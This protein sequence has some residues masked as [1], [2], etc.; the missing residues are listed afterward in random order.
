MNGNTSLNEQLLTDDNYHEIEDSPKEESKNFCSFL[1][2]FKCPIISTLMS[3]IL[4]VVPIAIFKKDIYTKHIDAPK[5][6][7]IDNRINFAFWTIHCIGLIVLPILMKCL[8]KDKL[9]QFCYFIPPVMMFANDLSYCMPMKCYWIPSLIEYLIAIVSILILP[10][11]SIYVWKLE[12]FWLGEFTLMFLTFV[13]ISASLDA[14]TLSYILFGR[15]IRLSK[16]LIPYPSNPKNAISFAEYLIDEYEDYIITGIYLS[17]YSLFTIFSVGH[18]FLMSFKNSVLMIIPFLL[19][20]TA[21]IISNKIIGIILFCQIIIHILYIILLQF[22]LTR[23]FLAEFGETC[24][25]DPVFRKTGKKTM[26]T[27][28]IG[29]VITLLIFTF[30]IFALVLDGNRTKFP[31]G[32]FIGGLVILSVGAFLHIFNMM[33]QQNSVV[34][35]FAS[36]FIAGSV[37]LFGFGFKGYVPF[38]KAYTFSVTSLSWSIMLDIIAWKCGH[39]P[40]LYY[41]YRGLIV[42][43]SLTTIELF[44][45][46]GWMDILF[47]V[48]QFIMDEIVMGFVLE[49]GP[50]NITWVLFAALGIGLFCPIPCVVAFIIFFIFAECCC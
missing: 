6:E 35:V 15:Y 43:A 30:P 24:H 49:N 42:A 36:L 20:A 32:Y 48:V 50:E 14:S 38:I 8:F 10:F 1:N 4:V 21:T 28:L 12:N 5:L 9:F 34:P 16:I 29:D 41:I 26:T 3:I 27:V 37:Y 2:D 39:S 31:W 13:S 44:E 18:G 33:E 25:F 11:K 47:G 46:I 7:V 19:L 22:D 23:E 45:C 40:F 17:C